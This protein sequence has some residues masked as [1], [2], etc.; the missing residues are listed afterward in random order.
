VNFD[1]KVRR[2][3][4]DAVDM[5]HAHVGGVD[6]CAHA[7]LVAEE[8]IKDGKLA[9]QLQARYAGWD[10]PWAKEVMAGKQSLDQIADLALERNQD[11]AP[12]SGRQEL[13]ENLV[14]QFC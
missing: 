3:S 5:F 2:Q 11:V 1:A 9:Q 10:R 4:I 6:L 7:L 8:M 12:Q 13:L 14:N